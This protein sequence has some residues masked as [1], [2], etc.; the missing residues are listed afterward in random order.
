MSSTPTVNRVRYRPLV[1]ACHT[2]A[3][4][5]LESGP[6]YWL[7]NFRS[8][9]EPGVNRFARPFPPPA[10]ART[11]YR[12][13]ES[14]GG[15]SIG[16]GR[17]PPMRSA[18]RC[19]RRPVLTQQVVRTRHQAPPVVLTHAARTRFFEP[20]ATVQPSYVI[21]A[22]SS[23]RRG[24]AGRVPFSTRKPQNAFRPLPGYV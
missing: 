15:R 19:L 22:R 12:F 11:R 5:T 16:L 3:N 4:V 18:P 17:S 6:I 24:P 20:L 13:C 1:C 9:L 7:R 21:Y 2:P 23:R 10:R 14:I 8:K